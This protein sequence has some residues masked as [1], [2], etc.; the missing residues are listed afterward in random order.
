MPKFL[1]NIIDAD[2]ISTVSSTNKFT[3]AGDISKLAGIAAGA[4]VNQNAFSNVAVSGQTTVAAD[5]KTDTLTLVA[6]TNITITTDAA[7]DSITI[8]SSVGG[9]V[10]TSVAA[11][12]GMTFTT[13]TSTGSITM[14][15]PGSL[16]GS[17]INEVTA[18]S[19]THAVSLTA[20]NVGAASITYNNANAYLGA[21]YIST[22]SEKPNYFG[23]GKLKLQMLSSTNLGG[24]A[25]TWNDVLWMSSYTGVDVKPSN[26]LILG[27]S[28]EFIGF[29]RQDFD[30]AS[31]GTVRTIWHTGNVGSGNGLTLSGTTISMGTP[32]TLTTS[33]TNATT[34]TSHTH[35]VTFP[36]TSVNGDTGT[37]V[38]TAADVSAAT[39]RTIST[40]APSGGVSGDVWYVV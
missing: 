1:A 14:G 19:H 30:S 37:V 33:T 27:K 17:S 39:V 13:I 35:L 11:G 40:S 28:S 31:W 4:E 22:G 20:E 12:N 3:T 32:S 9:G 38:L 15:T 5:T 10:V 8:N 25:T 18:G 29:V 23:S 2:R 36:V 34:A 21:T 7:T 26:A 24:G 6:G 16:N